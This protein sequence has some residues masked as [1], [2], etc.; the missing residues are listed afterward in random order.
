MQEMG[1]SLCVL[2]KKGFNKGDWVLTKLLEEL[3]GSGCKVG[4]LQ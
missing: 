2:Y 3:R 4:L 1:T